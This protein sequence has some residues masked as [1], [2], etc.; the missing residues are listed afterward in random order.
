ML[1]SMMS[2][3]EATT[4]QPPAPIAT[5]GSRPADHVERVTGDCGTGPP[6][7]LQHPRMNIALLRLPVV[8]GRNKKVQVDTQSDRQRNLIPESELPGA[9]VGRAITK[10]PR[11]HAAIEAC[12]RDHASRP[13]GCDAKHARRVAHV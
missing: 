5:S 12:R 1:D 8:A 7:W 2:L 9:L 3:N 13:V 11:P 4:T 10:L 6:L